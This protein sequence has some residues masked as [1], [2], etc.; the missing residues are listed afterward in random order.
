MR[1]MW[2]DRRG[3]MATRADSGAASCSS[4]LMAS[5][6]PIAR[7]AR[8]ADHRPVPS[9][10]EHDFQIKAYYRHVCASNKLEQYAAAIEW[11]D[12]GLSADAKNVGLASERQKAVKAKVRAVGRVCG[13]P[14]EAE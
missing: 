11:A 10:R 3:K 14:G 6:A 9:P 5:P 12:R 2:V 4:A 7:G 8:V 13:S 1:K